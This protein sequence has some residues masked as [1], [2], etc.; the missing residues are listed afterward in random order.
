[1]T[2]RLHP[3]TGAIIA[4]AALA[5]LV[6][7]DPIAAA[8][9]CPPT[10]ELEMETGPVWQT[11]NDL[12]IPNSDAGTRFSLVDLVGG[13]PEFVHRTYL[14]WHIDE[15]HSLRGLYAPLSIEEAGTPAGPLTFNGDDFTAGAETSATYRFNSYRLTYRWLWRD[16]ESWRWRIG[17]TAKIRDARVRLRQGALVS[18]KDDVG[19]VPLLHIDG[20]RD[21]GA[22]W[23]LS[24]DLDALA[25]GPGR[26]EDLAVKLGYTFAPGWR[27]C[28]GYRMLEGG[29]DVDEVYSF[30]W[31]HYAV[32]S[33]A[34]AI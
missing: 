22:G 8:E 12:Q 28:A 31:L 5:L 2:T 20:V 21:L 11:V 34:V 14:T 29:A 1:M 15:R 18:T 4:C 13:G 3:L 7:A 26:A 25:G 17:F 10:L 23:H 9:R 32:V 27:L 33:L 6:C 24:L 30:A 16:G 19:F